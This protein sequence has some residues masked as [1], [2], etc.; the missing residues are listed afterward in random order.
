MRQQRATLFWYLTLLVLPFHSISAQDIAIQFDYSSFG[1]SII[2]VGDD[3]WLVGLESGDFMVY[4]DFSPMLAMLDTAGSLLWALPLD[5]IPGTELGIVREIVQ[6]P[7]SEHFYVTTEVTGCDYGLPGAL[8]Y[9]SAD[10]TKLWDL[11]LPATH[12]LTVMDNGDVVVG[13]A[14]EEQLS[15]I[16]SLGEIV[17]EVELP[18]SPLKLITIADN[19]IVALGEEQLIKLNENGEEIAQVTVPAKGVDLVNWPEQELIVALTED[20]LL[21]LDT[22]LGLQDER[23]LS[24]YGHF[25]KLRTQADGIYLLGRNPTGIPIL[26]NLSAT[27]FEYTELWVGNYYM[28]PNDFNI[29]NDQIVMVGDEVPRAYDEDYDD[30]WDVYQRTV[31]HAGSSFFWKVIDPQH[32]TDPTSPDVGVVDITVGPEI[33]SVELW[34]CDPNMEPFYR[35]SLKDVEITVRNYG[36]VPVDLL[37][38]NMSSAPCSFHCLSAVTFYRRYFNLDLAPGDTITLDFGDMEAVGEL[39]GTGFTLC[40]FTSTPNL[41]MDADRSNNHRCRQIIY[42][43]LTEEPG[44]FTFSIFPNPVTDILRVSSSGSIEQ[45]E[46]YDIAGALI[47][48]WKGKSL[49]SLDVSHLPDGLY[50]LKAQ[51]E[52]KELVERFVKE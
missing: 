24:S 47:R 16:D 44:K 45:L 43:D 10:G 3:R 9:F 36:D 18:F 28:M 1:E 4:P 8:F 40:A 42:S 6:N 25:S 11:E 31:I 33:E 22:D 51:A 26:I 17:W 29:R 7:F 2:P 27:F 52:G 39:T 14:T 32:P 23:D 20:G 46:L 19:E 48:Q 13:G 49:T 15:R 12:T 37:N 30:H 38:L 5:D 34:P 35:F 21:L 41:R 50:L